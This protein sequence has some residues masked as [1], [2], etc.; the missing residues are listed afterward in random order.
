MDA[1]IV[2]GVEVGQLLE[3]LQSVLRDALA[4]SVGC[5]AESFLYTSAAE[6]TAVSE[7]GRSLG[8]ET[9]LAILQI[10]DHAL[11][12]MRYSTQTRTLAETAL[13]RICSLENL[14]ELAALL[15][16]LPAGGEATPI[17]ARSPRPG[18]SSSG[19]SA[20]VRPSG[21][22][23]AEEAK[24]K[25]EPTLNHAEPTNGS[26]AHSP[27][28]GQS[29][30]AAQPPAF[31]PPVNNEPDELARTLR[32]PAEKGI[33]ANSAEPSA[34]AETAQIRLAPETVG[35]LWQTALT[36]LEGDLIHDWAVKASG[37]AISA[38]NRL[39]VT[40]P[41]QYNF[42]KRCCEQPEKLAELERAVSQAAG[43]PVRLEFALQAGEVGGGPPQGRPV[44]AKGP[45]TSPRQLLAEKS[46]HPF[47]QHVAEV[48]GAV[49]VKAEPPAG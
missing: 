3:Q 5:P 23:Q 34:A 40:F 15:A 19:A 12:R 20:V 18:A 8:T 27:A 30:A 4:A 14:D 13:V 24:K 6:H 33:A 11:A 37:V 45:A 32:G 17:A 7:A 31:A 21:P 44:A 43:M 22:N 39:V 1:A 38:P 47:V 16:E 48:L 49:A 28:A 2:E 36:G 26:A 29:S 35:V 10:L 46:T 9:I 42:H 25:A 41:Q